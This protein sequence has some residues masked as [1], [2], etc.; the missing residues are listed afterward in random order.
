MTPKSDNQT[1]HLDPSQILGVP[2]LDQQHQ[3][4]LDLLEQLEKAPEAL[5]TSEGINEIMTRL[6][7]QFPEHFN[8][9][10]EWMSSHGVPA[11]TVTEH[12][13]EHTKILEDLT[14]LQAE[15]MKRNTIK[16]RSIVQIV[17]QWILHHIGGLDLELKKYVKP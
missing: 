6:M 7:S 3:S 11:E 17:R 5:I 1:F 8:T 15:A 2:T 16:V 4:I 12:I 9:E 13:A 14:L 10:E